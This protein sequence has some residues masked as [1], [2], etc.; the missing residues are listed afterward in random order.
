[1]ILPMGCLSFI[2]SVIAP[3]ALILCLANDGTFVA[4]ITKGISIKILARARARLE[5]ESAKQVIRKYWPL[6]L[7]RYV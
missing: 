2:S 1:M 6:S 3:P 4:Y 5:G 7:A